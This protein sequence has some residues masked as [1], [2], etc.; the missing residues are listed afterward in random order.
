[1]SSETEVPAPISTVKRNGYQLPF[2]MLLIFLIGM[3]IGGGT[4]FVGGRFLLEYVHGP[5]ASGTTR[6]TEELRART[7]KQGDDL[8]RLRRDSFMVGIHCCRQNDLWHGH[9]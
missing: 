9:L 2:K 6:L 5:M 1:M 4:A 3:F 7:L 8:P